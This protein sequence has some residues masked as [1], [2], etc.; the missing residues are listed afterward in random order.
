MGGRVTT[1]PWAIPRLSM[2]SSG[3]VWGQSGTGVQSLFS[4]TWVETTSWA[5]NPEA[6]PLLQR[7]RR[8]CRLFCECGFQDL[9]WHEYLAGIRGGR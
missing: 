7:E 1:L 8:R 6:A 5:T 9:L 3:P 2:A 4:R